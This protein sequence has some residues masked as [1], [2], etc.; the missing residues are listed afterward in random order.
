VIVDETM[1]LVTGGVG[2]TVSIG[3]YN[4]TCH[5]WQQ[6]AAVVTFSHLKKELAAE[7]L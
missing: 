5:L 4:C 1:Q 2:R 7:F 6:F 3:T